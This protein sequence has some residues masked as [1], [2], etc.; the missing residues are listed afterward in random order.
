V[1]MEMVTGLRILLLVTDF[2]YQILTVVITKM[3]LD[4]RQAIANYP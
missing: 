2:S 3:K 4:G 1:K